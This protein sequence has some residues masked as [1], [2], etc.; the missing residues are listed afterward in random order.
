MDGWCSRLRGRLYK[1]PELR[2][3]WCS[4][5]QTWLV[6]L[7]PWAVGQGAW[8]VGGLIMKGLT[9]LVRGLLI[10]KNW[11]VVGEQGKSHTHFS[12][13][14]PKIQVVELNPEPLVN[15][16]YKTTYMLALVAET[17]SLFFFLVTVRGRSPKKLNITG[18]FIFVL[19]PQLTREISHVVLALWMLLRIFISMAISQETIRK[20]NKQD[21]WDIITGATLFLSDSDHL[22]FIEWKAFFQCC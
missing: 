8:Q 10:W 20:L 6:K 16:T 17:L 9:S 14:V 5:D 19:L 18:V 21:L 22:R 12:L 15:W 13:N 1:D 7:G 4:A 2:N 3:A 11:R